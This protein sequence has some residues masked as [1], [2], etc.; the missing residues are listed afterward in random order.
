LLLIANNAIMP[1]KQRIILTVTN[2]LNY[3]QR[4]KRICSSLSAAGY[5]VTLVGWQ[6]ETSTPLQQRPFRQKRLRVPWQQGKQMYLYYWL[7]LFCYLLFRKA[8]AICA[9]DLDTIVPVY[10]ASKIKRTKRLYDAH[11]IFTEMQEVVSRPAVKKL[12]SR[13]GNRYVPMFP[14]GYTI[15]DAYAAFFK[16]QYHVAY[17][18]VRNATVLRPFTVP[19]KKERFILY[20]GAVNVGRC[21]EYLIPAMQQVAGKLVIIGKGNFYEQTKMLITQYHVE[22]K[23]CLLGYKSPEELVKYTEQAWVGI[24]LF[25]ITNDGKSNYLSMANRFF[26][27]MH[28]GV[29]QLCMDYPEYRKVN[30]QFEIAALI[31]NLEPGT[32]AAALNKLLQDETW[33]KQLETNALL[34]R[35]VYCWQEEEQKLLHVYRKLF[36]ASPSPGEN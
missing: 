25:D 11:E 29:P 31:D 22:D 36:E 14:A 35:E 28:S 18:V 6:W 34:A 16:Q 9:I 15:G 32:I 19:K 33:H 20:Q 5:D 3:D 2:D 26:D 12:W 10:W 1:Q 13:I 8:D 27:Y 24:T 17:E 30:E 4:M 21:F 7:K 23:V